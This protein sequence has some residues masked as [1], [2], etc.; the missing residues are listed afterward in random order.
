MC[1][2][3]KWIIPR[4]DRRLGRKADALAYLS[5]TTR[6]WLDIFAILFCS[7]ISECEPERIIQRSGA[8]TGELR[9]LKGSGKSIYPRER[10]SIYRITVRGH[11]VYILASYLQE[12][13]GAPTGGRPQ[14]AKPACGFQQDMQPLQH[15]TSRCGP[16]QPS[17][18]KTKS[19]PHP[20]QNQPSPVCSMPVH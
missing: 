17:R 13:R 18:I 10:V 16:S 19:T 4:A 20:N 1:V 5:S 7:V 8:C 15:S 6:D 2:E 11:L 9:W 14:E 12:K 3:K